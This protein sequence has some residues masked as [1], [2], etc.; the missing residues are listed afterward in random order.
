MTFETRKKTLYLGLAF[1][2]MIAMMI[3][4]LPDSV[5]N[6][7]KGFL[8]S[9][10]QV[11]MGILLFSL[12]LW[13]T[14]ALPFHITG[15]LSVVLLALFDVDTFKN[16]VSVGFGNHI[17]TFFIGVLILSAF[18]TKSLPVISMGCALPL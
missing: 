13:M 5:R 8:T 7:G 3:L 2:V 1:T 14:E 9:E 12:V 15:M 16:I 11:A 17:I 18:I 6:A 10:G 4:P